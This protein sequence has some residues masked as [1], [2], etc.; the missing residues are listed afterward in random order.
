MSK[1]PLHA[2]ENDKKKK[3]FPLACLRG[4]GDLRCGILTLKEKT[5][6]DLSSSV[7]YPWDLVYLNRQEIVNDVARLKLKPCTKKITGVSFVNPK[8][9]YIS[10]TAKIK[11]GVVLDAEE[12]PV[13][14]DG[15]AVIMANS[16]IMGPA[17]IGKGSVV[18]AGARIY[19]GTSIGPMC[20][21]GGEIEESI[22][23]GY[24]NKQH[25]G[26]LGHSFICEW[27]NIGA[28]TSNSDLKNNYSNVKVWNDG[29]Q[30]DTG[31]MF[32]GLFI[33][34]HSKCGINTMFNTGTVVGVSCNL[35]GHG[36][37]PKHIPSF[38]WGGP[39]KMTK[40][41]IERAVK[42][43]RAVMKRRDVEMTE[44]YEKLFRKVFEEASRSGDYEKR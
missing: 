9:I 42:T 37:M 22:F 20:K 23:Q 10:K 11:P 35:F 3:L 30:V 34:D 41:D 40:F 39:E 13:V 17:Y 14:I 18:K 44:E 29:E 27:V 32:A 16:S 28:G 4:I 24:S 36:Y 15:G 43:A 38:S 6:K 2:P 5:G 21:V 12:G 19:P 31:K 8:K 1:K 33:G 7:I 25:D 26:F